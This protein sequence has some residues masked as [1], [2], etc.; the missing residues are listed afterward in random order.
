MELDGNFDTYLMLKNQKE[1]LAKDD[2]GG[3]H[4]DA[5]IPA[6]HGYW[7]VPKTGNYVVEVTSSKPMDTGVFK[8]KLEQRKPSKRK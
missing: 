7:R 6:K 2:N 8:L 4:R 3:H 5:R 1:L